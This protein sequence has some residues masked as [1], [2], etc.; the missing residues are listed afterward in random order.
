MSAFVTAAATAIVHSLWQIA[1]V[2]L[3][4]RLWLALVGDSPRAAYRGACLALASIPL[5]AGATFA[6]ALPD[7]A[8][9]NDAELGN[10]AD[11]DR[12]R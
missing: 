10:A 2:A 6:R 11:P 5:L 12:A 4:L 1:L 7:S 9:D 3:A 8:A